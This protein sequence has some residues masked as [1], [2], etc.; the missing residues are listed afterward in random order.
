MEEIIENQSP[1]TGSTVIVPSNLT[2]ETTGNDRLVSILYRKVEAMEKKVYDLETKKIIDET[3]I[4]NE[5][6]ENS[7]LLPNKPKK[8]KRGRGYRPLLQ[9]EIE[10][11]K[12][13]GVSCPA[14][15]RW[16]GVA[17]STY[18]K[19]SKKY[20]IW[21]P[22]PTVKG[23]RRTFDPTRGKYPLVKILAGE[24]NGNPAISEW[25]VRKKLLLGGTFPSKCD[26]C[27]YD[28]RRIGD[29]KICLLL[30]HKD[31]DMK[32]FKLENLRLLCLNCTFECGR[33]YIRN[34]K[35]TFD[36]DWIQGADKYQ[37]DPGTSNPE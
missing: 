17:L 16:M 35:H 18:K 22:N 33:G 4:P 8:L 9:S 37:I 13:H 30:D 11:A 19:Y 31:G 25:V 36:P 3:Q 1:D 15:A 34:G 24:F 20:G 32:N 12:K 7:G 27:G 14:Q 28:K 2:Y 23:K 5:I 10:E 6:L 26:I 21:H 29:N